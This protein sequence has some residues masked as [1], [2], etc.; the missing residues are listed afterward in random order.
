MLFEITKIYSSNDLLPQMAHAVDNDLPKYIGR[1]NLPQALAMYAK[2]LNC[3]ASEI[4]LL[5]PKFNDRHEFVVD[6]YFLF[7]VQLINSLKRTGKVWFNTED[8]LWRF[9]PKGSLDT[10]LGDAIASCMK[11]AIYF[12]N[13]GAKLYENM[14]I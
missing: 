12:D 11:Y 7:N 4:A 3:N 5:D 9:T 6:V 10:D 8:K 13:S 1:K 2:H 14:N